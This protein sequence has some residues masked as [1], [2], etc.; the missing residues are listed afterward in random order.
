LKYTY[1]VQAIT[2]DGFATVEY[3]HEQLGSVLKT[4]FIPYDTINEA[5]IHRTIAEQFPV[6]MFYSRYLTT[7]PAVPYDLT[8]ISGELDIHFNDRFYDVQVEVGKTVDV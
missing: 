6:T 5:N 2:K 7:I 8:L 4:V 1:E 3:R